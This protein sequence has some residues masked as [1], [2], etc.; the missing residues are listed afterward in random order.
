[1]RKFGFASNFVV[2]NAIDS[3]PFV[4]ERGL[5][6]VDP[7]S[8]YLF[9]YCAKVFS[10]LLSR[11]VLN[12]RVGGIKGA[13]NAPPTSYLLFTDDSMLFAKANEK[14]CKAATNE[15]MEVYDKSQLTFALSVMDNSRR[16][17][18]DVL[19]VNTVQVPSNTSA[20]LLKLANQKRWCSI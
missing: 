1:M 10:N 6:Q 14:E 19:G 16:I 11:S 8:T 12:G 17:I 2:I 13:R 7:I 5:H 18:L 20:Y 9:I 3:K 15:V 4:S